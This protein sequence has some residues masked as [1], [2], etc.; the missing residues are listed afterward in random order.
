MERYRDVFFAA[1][2]ALLL[3]SSIAGISSNVIDDAHSYSSN[4][5]GEVLGVLQDAVGG[6]TAPGLVA[7][8][9]T[10]DDGVVFEQAFGNHTYTKDSPEI[11]AKASLW[12]IASLSKVT[13]TT[14]IAMKMYQDGYIN[15]EQKVVDIFGSGFST[16]DPRKSKIEIRNLLLHNAGWPP[17][18]TPNFW[19]PDFGCP[20]TLS[21]PPK[22]RKLVFTCLSRG[23]QGVFD[24]RLQ[25][26][27]GDQYLYSDLSMITLMLVLGRTARIHQLVSRESLDQQC[28]AAVSPPTLDLAHPIDACYFA[29]YAKINVFEPLI[30]LADSSVAF[31]GYRPSSEKKD[32][33][34]PTWNDTAGDAPAGGPP[35]R[36]RILQGQVSDGNAFA[37]GGV[38]GHAGV[39]ASAATLRALASELLKGKSEALR[40][41]KT[42]IDLFTSIKNESQSSRALGWDTNS[43]VANTYRGCGNFSSQTFTHTGY[44]GTQICVDPNGPR[45]GVVTVLLTNRV[46]PACSD[47]SERKIHALRQHFNNAVLSTLQ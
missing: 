38:S 25:Y 44:T 35:Y 16:K 2:T 24:Q 29:A 37:L 17:D 47:E 42:T 20:E 39:F 14:T 28:T 15:L 11:S 23:F 40:L 13:A 5:W 41:N 34:V 27:P 9:A 43:Y 22:E 19:T 26:S 45:G 4:D 36:Q 3:S 1:I 31:I 12:D 33:C 7:V 46:Y 32:R 8:V 21:K 30:L 18:P 6:G 10:G